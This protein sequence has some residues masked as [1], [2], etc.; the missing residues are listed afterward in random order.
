MDDVDERR[1]FRAGE[2]SR[3]ILGERDVS[4]GEMD[5]WRWRLPESMGLRRGEFEHAL[6][7]RDME[8]SDCD[9]LRFGRPREY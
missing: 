5:R 8:V 6:P 4:K 9:R 1:E 7:G 3:E 2:V